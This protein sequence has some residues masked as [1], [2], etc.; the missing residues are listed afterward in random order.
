MDKFPQPHTQTWS[1]HICSHHTPAAFT[2]TCIPPT[3]LQTPPPYSHPVP[4]SASHHK[5]SSRAETSSGSRKPV[6]V[7]MQVLAVTVLG[8][9]QQY[10]DTKLS[11]SLIL[12]WTQGNSPSDP[13]PS[14]RGPSATHAVPHTQVCSDE[15]GPQPLQEVRGTAGFAWLP[16]GLFALQYGA[17]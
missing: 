3:H 9:G 7:H 13:P 6:M 8:W 10:V 2:Y 11:G 17:L 16:P 1:L 12:L 4:D 15:H 5:C 14:V